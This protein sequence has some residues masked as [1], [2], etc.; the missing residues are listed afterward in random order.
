MPS[1][2]AP[3][4][5]LALR[6]KIDSIDEEMLDLLARRFNVTARVGELKAESGLDSVDPVREQEKLERLRALAGEKSL[7]SEFI[8]D[9]FQTLFDEVV[10]NHRNFL[11]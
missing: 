10:K 1:Q 11:K 5:L 4:E 7:N 2:Q 3:D 6:E 9:L 8:L